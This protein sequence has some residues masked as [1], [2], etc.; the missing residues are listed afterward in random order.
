[1]S[2]K[3][4]NIIEITFEKLVRFRKLI[5]TIFLIFISIAATILIVENM[6]SEDE[7]DKKKKKEQP[8]QEVSIADQLAGT[9]MVEA[10]TSATD[11]AGRNPLENQEELIEIQAFAT[12][13]KT[14]GYLATVEDGIPR[15]RGLSM[16]KIIGGRWFFA[17]SKLKGVSKQ[18]RKYPYAEW[19]TYD[20]N[21]NVSLRVL[22]K[23]TTVEDRAI[24][25][26]A[27]NDVPVLEAAY[28]DKVD[29]EFELFYMDIIEANWYGKDDQ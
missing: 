26:Q 5:I 9:P 8:R 18:I 15:V 16:I 13:H 17:T 12:K 10:M 24:K 11:K 2:Q 25:M 6:K 21:S 27:I 29:T 28:W 7:K 4:K 1:M 19:I 20:R 23:V 3:S 22:G 14:V